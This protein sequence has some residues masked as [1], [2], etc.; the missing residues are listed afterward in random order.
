MK[1]SALI[2][3]L[4]LFL[5]MDMSQLNHHVHVQAIKC[6]AFAAMFKF[7]LVK[8]IKFPSSLS[9]RPHFSIQLKG[10]AH[11]LIFNNAILSDGRGNSFERNLKA[12]SPFNRPLSS[13]FLTMVTIFGPS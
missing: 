6:V 3:C 10:C 11:I 2:T 12:K 7:Y 8:T 9:L 13:T 4:N 1:L 5:E